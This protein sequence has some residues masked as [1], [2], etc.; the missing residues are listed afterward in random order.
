MCVD[1]IGS[2][3]VL[4]VVSDLDG[5]VYRGEA[6]IPGAVEAF[7]RWHEGGVPY[8]FVTNNATKTPAQFAAK[9]NRLGV[10]V[11]P[12][13]VFSAAS[14]TATFVRRRWPIGTRIFAIGEA[15]LLEPLAAGEF[16]VARDDAQVVVL[17]FDYQIDYAKLRTAIRA[18]L[19]GAELVVTNPDV[20]SPSES[21][22]EPCVGAFLAAIRA[23]VPAAEPIVV[24]KPGPIMI[25][26]AL[27]SLEV[28]REHAIM[29]GDQMATDIAGGKRAGLRT[30]LV[31]TGVPFKSIVG[32]EPDR[33][34]SSLLDL[35][36]AEPLERAVA[37][38]R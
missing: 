18:L 30:V 36:V 14:A 7:R 34:V 29:I 16:V 8:A 19:G 15:C 23:A 26:E 20:L 12:D 4:G 13:R 17:G 24:G 5:V 10:A 32:L 38:S 37:G 35:F 11:T 6:A 33:I 25:E 2:E 21:G 28:S 27:G 9:L 31:T 22:F 1:R 3:R